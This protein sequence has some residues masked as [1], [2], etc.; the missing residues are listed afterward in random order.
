MWGGRDGEEGMGRKGWGGG[1]KTHLFLEHESFE[2]YKRSLSK[3]MHEF[4]STTNL[5]E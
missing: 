3:H 4:A 2:K 5:L 1:E